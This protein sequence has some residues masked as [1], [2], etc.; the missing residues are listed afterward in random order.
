MKDIIW[1]CFCASLINILF[2]MSYSVQASMLGMTWGESQFV[3]FDPYTG[4]VL[5]YHGGLDPNEGFV[6]LT[7][8]PSQN[9]LFAAAQVSNS[10]YKVNSNTGDFSYLGSIG[11]SQGSEV[12]TSIAFDQSA[13]TLYATLVSNNNFGGASVWNSKL[14]AVSTSDASVESEIDL[15]NIFAGSLLF[16]PFD[17]LLYALTADSS[18]KDG[19]TANEQLSSVDPITGIVKNLFPSQEEILIGLGV[20]PD[21]DKL[22]GWANRSDGHFFTEIDISTGTFT[23]LASADPSDACCSGFLYEDFTLAD[24]NFDSPPPSGI[25]IPSAV[26]LFF[27]SLASLLVVTRK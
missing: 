20:I 26:W 4:N 22:I 24:V 5:G 19:S 15:G 10:L 12:V 23:Q 1:R 17:G 7:R 14:V 2:L 16:N 18:D 21:G 6:G 25:P 11:D 9:T 13:D 27:S 8:D 3:S